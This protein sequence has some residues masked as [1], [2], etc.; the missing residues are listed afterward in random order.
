MK[1]KKN[2]KKKEIQNWY[3]IIFQKTYYNMNVQI[4]FYIYKVQII[5]H[6]VYDEYKKKKNK[7][8]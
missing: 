3:K 8:Y 6:S 4:H 1:I 7:I 2:N 5:E